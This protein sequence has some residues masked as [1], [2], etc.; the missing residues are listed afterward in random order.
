M[1]EA[2]AVAIK[3]DL[4][5]AFFAD[6]RGRPHLT[7]VFRLGRKEKMMCYVDLENERQAYFDCLMI[8]KF[9][10]NGE[11]EVRWEN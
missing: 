10:D 8:S 9:W 2:W 3:E 6:R 1:H 5:Y 4:R 11:I 7:L